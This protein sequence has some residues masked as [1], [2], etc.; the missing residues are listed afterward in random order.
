MITSSRRKSVAVVCIA[1]V[2]FAALA[3]V[4]AADLVSL[5]LTALWLVLPAIAVT[6]VRRR[7]SRCDE[8][9][10]SLLSLLLSRAPPLLPALA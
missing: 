8:Q 6:V 7:A 3:P 9:T 4:V 1:L 5:V 10:V 2:V